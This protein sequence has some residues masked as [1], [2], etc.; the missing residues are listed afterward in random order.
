MQVQE[1]TSVFTTRAKVLLDEW[2]LHMDEPIQPK[3]A[4]LGFYEYLRGSFAE[5]CCSECGHMWPSKR[6]LVIFHFSL[7]AANG[8]GTVKVRCCKQECC[9][10]CLPSVEQPE[11]S[12]DTIDVMVEK[13]IEKIKVRCYGESMGEANRTSRFTGDMNGPHESDLCEACRQG[14]CQLSM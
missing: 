1:W 2:T 5:F 6:V 7:D 10:C 11:F 8:R 13:L 3:N 14:I 12:R 9:D 4:Q